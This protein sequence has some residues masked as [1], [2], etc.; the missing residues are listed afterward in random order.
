[1]VEGTSEGSLWFRQGCGRWALADRAMDVLF[2]DMGMGETSRTKLQDPASGFFPTQYTIGNLS[3]SFVWRVD[4]VACARPERG[5]ATLRYCSVLTHCW[6]EARVVHETVEIHR[7][8]WP[9]REMSQPPPPPPPHGENPKTTSSGPGFPPGTKFDV[10]IV[11]EHSA[12]SGFL[13][14]PSLK[15]K[16]NSFCAGVAST[17]AAVVIG[18]SL[19]PAIIVWWSNFQGLGNAGMVLLMVAIGLGAWSLG[20][21]QGDSPK[22][23]HSGNERDS[24]KPG[25][26]FG[27]SGSYYTPPP[28][29]GAP[30]PTSEAPPPPPPPPPPQQEAPRPSQSWQE[31]PQAAPEPQP[32]P[33]QHQPSPSPKPEPPP[34]PQPPPPPPPQQPPPPPQQ[35]QPKPQPK[36]APPPPQP[37]PQPEPQPPPPRP[38]ATRTETPKG[39]WEKAREE[40]RKRDQERKAKEAE[41]KKREETARRLRELRE[42]D[43]REQLRE[44]VEKELREKVEK[45]AREREAKEREAREREAQEKEEARRKEEDRLRIERERQAARE[46]EAREAKARKDREE[47]LERLRKELE[48]RKEE[49]RKEKERKEQ[50]EKATRKGTYAFSSV[51]E[52]TSMWP[53]GK[54][55]AAA[56]APKPP[57]SASSSETAKPASPSPPSP[58]KPSPAPSPGP[59]PNRAPPNRAPPSRAP[60]TAAPST[61]PPPSARS[62]TG[63]EDTYSYRPYDKPKKPAARKTSVSD[64]S[65]SSWA[66]SAT[67]TARTSPPPSMR[68]PYTT[69]DPQKI[70]IKAVYG[71]LNQFSKTPA[72][73]L[74]S[75]VGSVT[76]GLILR[77]TSAGLFVDDDVRGV[78]QR[79]WDVKAWTL[80][81]VEVWC[82]THT[83]ASASSTPPSAIPTNHPF[84]KTMPTTARRAAERGAPKTLTGDEA[85][86]YL[87][88]F[89]RMCGSTCR[90]GLNSA[91]ASASSV[92]GSSSNNDKMGEW[93]GKGLHLL[94][95]TVRDAEGKRYLFVVSEEESWKI[96]KGLQTLRNG[97]QVRALGV[98]SFSSAEAKNTLETLGWGV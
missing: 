34:Q 1:M 81:L 6:S 27:G 9:R 42:R 35:E 51:G 47:R 4:T 60:S 8:L 68:G 2:R 97:T 56:A 18:Q 89:G 80:K 62:A 49:E 26:G 41:L 48:I 5:C 22:P 12:G 91:S 82:P 83:L 69:N 79:E 71:F 7:R 54:P 43:A 10:F 74:I 85:A 98:Q 78:A 61:A 75:G 94:R 96:A 11:P 40:T 3:A 63:T 21:T 72:S 31:R 20:R 93:K 59:A 14:L 87:D 90:N 23:R 33:Q 39:A 32:Q 67:S 95:A 92:S 30:P 86:T 16:W 65:E 84:F 77:I 73:Q 19:A 58:T 25:G 46:R 50:E 15:P 55:P 13:Y 36:S 17:L 28:N 38:S 70:V 57:P 64:F 76:D 37:E 53:N 24:S 45:E 66:P 44:K 88:E 29:T 52:K